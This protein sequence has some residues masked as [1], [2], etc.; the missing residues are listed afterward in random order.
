MEVD[1]VISLR[2]PEAQQG[3]AILQALKK[4]NAPVPDAAGLAALKA[5]P[6]PAG[7]KFTR[8]IGGES[9][10]R[11]RLYD[12][13]VRGTQAAFSMVLPVDALDTTFPDLLLAFE[14]AGCRRIEATAQADDLARS[15][16]VANG[17]VEVSS[18]RD[19]E[20]GDD[21]DDDEPGHDDD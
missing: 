19:E 14:A 4:L 1:I 16:A 15:Y 21:D 13:V 12:F 9:P 20:Y 5:L 11:F 3:A 2:A 8:V 18:G 10:Q 6:G 17:K 7:A